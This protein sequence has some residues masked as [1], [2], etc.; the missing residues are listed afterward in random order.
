METNNTLLIE[1]VDRAT[2]L[3]ARTIVLDGLRERF[4]DFDESFNP[5]LD[6]IMS[7]YL[8]QGN[9]F[10]VGKFERGQ[11][12]CTGALVA[13]SAAD[14]GRVARMSVAK[15]YR[16]RGL[17][18]VMLKFIERR[19]IDK[20]YRSLLLE[21]NKEWVDAIMFYTNHGYEEVERDDESIH[22]HKKL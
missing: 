22:F 17:A 15:L 7:H 11:V 12:V 5:D 16:R 6:D 13:E 14:T 21:T 8:G 1:Q 9:E 18:G 10:Y 2:Q 20:G 19:A 3:A 4:D